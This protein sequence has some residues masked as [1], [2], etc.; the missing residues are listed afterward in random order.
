MKTNGSTST[1]AAKINLLKTYSSQNA[2][3]F[4][5]TIQSV[6]N[7][8]IFSDKQSQGIAGLRVKTPVTNSPLRFSTLSLLKNTSDE[9]DAEC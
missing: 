7:R 9:V 8:G 3:K 4:M 5:F 1:S 6:N 2:T